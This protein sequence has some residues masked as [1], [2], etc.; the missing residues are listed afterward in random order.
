MQYNSVLLAF[1][2]GFCAIQADAG[3]L[4]KPRWINKKGDI[5]AAPVV[6]P[7]IAAGG[8]QP[9]TL[10]LPETPVAAAPAA[11]G[12]AAEKGV[13]DLQAFAHLLPFHPRGQQEL[14][15]K[16]RCVNFL[17][18]LLEKSAYAPSAVGSLMPKCKW[19][20]AECTALKDDLIRRLTSAAPAPAAAGALLQRSKQPWPERKAPKDY[21]VTWINGPRGPQPDFATEGG[22]DESIYGWCDTMYDMMRKKAIEELSEEKRK[23]DEK[24]QQAREAK[25]S[26]QFD[27]D[28]DDA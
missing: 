10:T 23:L 8:A 17:N 9:V 3:S 25:R 4:R 24:L 6:L 22:M 7:V 28:D 18:H 5:S 20:E 1:V 27:D 21:S 14:L 2:L 19:S 26:E 11:A 13:G 12:P 15:M 16:T